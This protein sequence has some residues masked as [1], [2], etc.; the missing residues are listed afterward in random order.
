[1]SIIHGAISVHMTQ[2]ICITTQKIQSQ[3]TSN[4]MKQGDKY[5]KTKSLSIFIHHISPCPSVTASLL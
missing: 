2:V 5:I 3:T 4:F 1:M